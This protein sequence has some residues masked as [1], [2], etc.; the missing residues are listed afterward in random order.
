MNAASAAVVS[1]MM[2]NSLPPTQTQI[3]S[4]DEVSP[5]EEAAKTS[6]SDDVGR[7][8]TGERSTDEL[9]RLGQRL[10]RLVVRGKRE[11]GVKA[12]P[13]K[14]S[15]GS[16][17][18]AP[19]NEGNNGKATTA[20]G[21]SQ[22]LRLTSSD[23][24]RPTQASEAK[25]GRKSTAASMLK[26]TLRRMTGFGGAAKGGEPTVATHE[27]KKAAPIVTCPAG[28]SGSV[29]DVDQSGKP[30]LTR[31][32]SNSLRRPKNRDVTSA[33]A[34]SNGN[35]ATLPRSG[36]GG[37]LEGRPVR[38]SLSVHH[39]QGRKA[40]ERDNAA[41]GLVR[42]SRAVQTQLTKD[43]LVDGD[44]GVASAEEGVAVGGVQSVDFSLFMPD[45]LGAEV[46]PVET[47]AAEPQPTEPVDVRRNRALTLDNMKLT[48]EVE[49][50]RLQS[51]EAARER[52]TAKRERRA[53]AARAED[54]QAKLTSERDLRA[55]LERRMDERDE[56]MR[57]IAASMENVEKEF[58]NR[59]EN[60]Q[61]LEKRLKEYAEATQAMQADL[62]ASQDLA[63]E[64]RTQLDRSLEKQRT[65]LAQLREVETEA[66]ELQEFLQAEKMTLAETLK[67]CE[68][69]ISALKER[70]GRL[71]A[72]NAGLEERCSHLVRL[73]EQRHQETL[74]L[75]AQLSG[76][77][78]R[79]KDMLLSQGAELSRASVHVSELHSRLE[80]L[81]AAD[82]SSP[83]S[84]IVQEESTATTTTQTETR[85]QTQ[86]ADFNAT[87]SLASTVD[88]S[89]EGSD[90]LQNLSRAITQRQ[91]SETA[92]ELVDGGQSESSQGSLP[93]L[94]ERIHECSSML[95]KL[96]K[97]RLSTG[98]WPS[99]SKEEKENREDPAE[100]VIVTR[101][102]K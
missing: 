47:H 38:R 70:S 40:K 93:S 66:R 41:F 57:A 43:A 44:E 100:E 31:A 49:R 13:R 37:S 101:F 29:K 10:E 97:M 68:T 89:L 23:V 50:L 28:R 91:K 67:D 60:I 52:D 14:N 55:K 34:A 42:K 24:T 5:S 11:P 83:S 2:T 12:S 96:A 32:A 85:E 26:T 35:K 20:S 46:D 86:Q 4:Q 95:D 15:A 16:H 30:Y 88:S 21:M 69:E 53:A 73:S 58:D 78:E 71:E 92:H 9:D 65:L 74:A 76:V 59:D 63:A 79:A 22:S 48:R 87:T 72:E 98:E 62:D 77:Q 56:K 82:S 19:E 45:L 8:S 25:A 54:L 39:Q 61:H 18:P 81:L 7:S 27:D 17:I 36:T 3:N 33:T 90:S 1:A 6:E 84:S 51:A 64:L 99:S 80:R 75:Q 94:V 102:N